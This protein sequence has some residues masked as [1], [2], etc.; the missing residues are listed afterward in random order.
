MNAASDPRTLDPQ[1]AVPTPLYP[2]PQM[3]PVDFTRLDTL[4]P[5][6]TKENARLIRVGTA[7]ATLGSVALVLSLFIVPWF[8]VREVS[9]VQPPP[10]Q[11]ST[12]TN[13]TTGNGNQNQPSLSTFAPRLV[14]RDLHDFGIVAWASTRREKRD[15]AIVVLA[16]LTQA[17][18]L[19]SSVSYRWR[20]LLTL[21]GGGAL[22]VIVLTLI[23]YQHL[24]TLIRER[25]ALA[26][27]P[28]S[29]VVVGANALKIAGVRPGSGMVVLLASA[30][31]VLF[32]VLIAL[33]GG[34]RGKVLAPVQQ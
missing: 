22:A 34:R 7:I 12:N 25:V 32:G 33:M 11:V 19:V 15:V 31:I 29:T 1:T 2:G 30:G 3:V 4:P 16:L 24:A 21:A 23:D 5:P 6:P 20:T 14:Q 28:T 18:V 8:F 9:V 26:V 17:A 13:T 10:G 27:S